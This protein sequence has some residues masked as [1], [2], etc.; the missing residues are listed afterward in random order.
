[1]KKDKKQFTVKSRMLLLSILPATIIGIGL[2]L[3]G[4]FFMKEG[5]EAEIIKG[6]LASAYTYKDI[7]V[8]ESA[9]EAGDNDL[10]TDLKN[11][12]G[13]DFTW[14]D[15][16]TRKNS[17]LGAQVIGTQAADS[18]ISAVIR[19]QNTFTSRNTQVAGQAYFVAYVP[20]LENGQTVAMAFTGVPRTSVNN[21]IKSSVLYMA[22]VAA[23]FMLLTVIISFNAARKM[24][25]AINSMNTCI[26]HIANGE[27]IK[28]EAHMDR[29]DEIGSVLRHTNL[30]IDRL[31]EVVK[32][33]KETTDILEQSSQE[34]D[35]TSKSIAT[36]AENVTQAVG[37][38]SRGATEQAES[39]QD[40][41]ENVSNI[42]VAVSSVSDTADLLAQ[43]AEGMNNASKN[44]ETSLLRLEES[45]RQM[46]SNIEEISK[47]ISETSAA[48]DTVNDKVEMINNIASQTNLLALN[49]SIEAARAGEAGRGF[50]VVAT[51]I[52]NLASDSNKTADEIKTEMHNLLSVTDVANDKADAVQKIGIEVT[53]V[54]ENTVKNIQELIDNINS[55]VT[56]VGQ[57]S[58]NTSR[59]IQSK[60]VVVDAMSSL[61]AI[62]EEN[63][64][65]TQETSASMEQLSSSVET[66]AGSAHGLKDLADKLGKDMEFFKN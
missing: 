39:I 18:V 62:S 66:L 53:G 54:L 9:R 37:E 35:N 44:T 31:G 28:A 64:A 27:F 65:S 3:T 41:T 7:A 61:S 12:T 23:I 20:V 48:V 38:V 6:L 55:T 4:I 36:T 30:L 26:E 63:A 33:V 10:E 60:D 51:E 25:G 17:S 46:S 1:M 19:G 15:G 32:D 13:Y 5:M 56:N 42:D 11:N 50:A 52:G 14:F 40:A 16:D 49:A 24:A 22:G 8:E 47:A 34:L 2:L 57:I 58:E 43:T 59:C 21:Q 45:F 29:N